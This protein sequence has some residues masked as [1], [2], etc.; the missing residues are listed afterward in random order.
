MAGR[1]AEPFP[2]R[3]RFTVNFER[4]C[5]ADFDLARTE[6]LIVY[7]DGEAKPIRCEQIDGWFGQI[8]YFIDCVTAQTKP[9]VVTVGDAVEAFE[10]LEAEERS[11]CG[12][13]KEAVDGECATLRRVQIKCETEVTDTEG[14]D[15]G[16]SPE[17]THGLG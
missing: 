7:E 12:Y 2:F 9:S 4:S 17:S 5:T 3:M 8:R 16:G 6:R 1:F 10:V 11:I 13:A 15:E 14:S